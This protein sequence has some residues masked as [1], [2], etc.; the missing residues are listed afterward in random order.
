MAKILFT[1]YNFLQTR[2]TF[3]SLGPNIFLEI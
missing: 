3:Y 1:V 2:V